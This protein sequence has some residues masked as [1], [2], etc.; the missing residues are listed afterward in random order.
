MHIVNLTKRDRILFKRTIGLRLDTTPDQT[1]LVRAALREMLL[2]HP[3]IT[4]DP[5]RVRVSDYGPYAIDVD[6]LAYVNTSDWNDFLA[7]QED[8]VLR[9]MDIVREVGTALALPPRI[10]Y[11]RRDSGL[12]SEREKA[13]ERQ[14][15]EWGDAHS[16]PF[17]DFP[18]DYRE[19]I[20][21]TLDYPPKGSPDYKPR[22]GLREPESERQ[23]PPHPGPRRKG[24]G[25][26]ADFD[27]N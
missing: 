22:P 14:L 2:A 10:L 15:R 23:G 27:E 3:R 20:T 5:A 13:A 16:L 25:I 7:V 17:P 26:G 19:Q 4:D 12:D 21:D 9:I 6:I 8:L 11:H 24:P 1:R 18:E